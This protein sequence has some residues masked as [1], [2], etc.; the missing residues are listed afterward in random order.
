MAIVW[1]RIS[2]IIDICFDRSIFVV[3]KFGTHF[4]KSTVTLQNGVTYTCRC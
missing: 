2:N 3:T 4:L 1:V